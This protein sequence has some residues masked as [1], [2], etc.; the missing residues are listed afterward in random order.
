MNGKRGG[1]C[2]LSSPSH[3]LPHL[4][5]QECLLV[6]PLDSEMDFL[7]GRV[8]AMKVRWEC[9]LSEMLLRAS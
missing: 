1:D 8:C 7:S 9:C 3:T 4:A 6:G 2:F 5:F